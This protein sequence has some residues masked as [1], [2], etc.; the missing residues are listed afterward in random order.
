MLYYFFTDIFIFL[1]EL[2]FSSCGLILLVWSLNFNF[3][4]IKFKQKWI[5]TLV[6][7]F[8]ETQIITLLLLTNNFN[9]EKIIF[10]DSFISNNYSIII[11]ILILSSTILFTILTINQ[12]IQQFATNFEFIILLLFVTF[13]LLVLVSSNDFITLYLSLELQSLSIYILVSFKKKLQFSSEAG[14]KYFIL[15]SLSSSLLLF[16]ISLIYGATGSTNFHDIMKISSI[17]IEFT[18]IFILGL[19]LLICGLLFKLTAVPFHIW[20][21]DIYEGAPFIIMIFLAT[22]PK[23]AVFSI[24]I[25]ILYSIFFNLQF[26]WQPILLFTAIITILFSSI[27][28]LYQKKIKRF[29]AYSSISHVGYML[30]ALSTGTILG[31]QS[32][33]VYL[34]IYLVTIFLFFGIL[35]SIQNKNNKNLIYL[36][37]FL[38]FK[39]NYP[40]IKII[41]VLLFFSIA[42][43][44]PLMGFFSKFYIFFSL[45]DTKY[46]ILG[47]VIVICSTLSTFYYIR[48]IK[49]LTFEKNNKPIILLLH[50]NTPTYLYLALTSVLIIFFISTPNLLLIETYYLT[51]LI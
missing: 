25:K 37:D 48:I 43:I 18:S 47:V 46:Y 41:L 13:S 5:K 31:L 12:I 11:K 21:P 24:F 20:S 16:G 1:P 26:I 15:G 9:K 22:I 23:L 36:I 49:I 32:V 28:T 14:L 8:L 51:L 7:L 38:T 34:L 42:G 39:N 29:F 44:P 6:Y 19:I 4:T 50:Q 45:V 17:N 30:A 3:K 27:I 35:L 33:F 10:Y 40:I 2:F